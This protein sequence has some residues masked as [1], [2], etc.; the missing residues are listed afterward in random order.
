[1]ANWQKIDKKSLLQLERHYSQFEPYCHLNVVDMWGWR[2]GPNHW[3]KVGDTVVYRLNDYN[4]GSLYLTI[5][6]RSSA[7]EAIR[8][9]CDKNKSLKKITLKC[10]PEVTLKALGRWNAIIAVD[11]DPDNHDYIFEVETMVKFSSLELQHK[12]PLYRKLVRK[13]PYLKVRV[14]DHNQAPDRRLIYRVFKR[15]VLQTNSQ[16]WRKEFLA[17]KRILNLRREKM[18]C[19]GF[20]DG[21]KAIGYTINEPE[22]SGYYQAFSGKADRGYRDLGLFMEHETAKYILDNYGSRFINLQPDQGLE[23][24]RDYKTSLG[25]QRQLKKYILIIDTAKATANPAN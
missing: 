21:R 24:L 1:M 14:L 5:L 13:H 22:S 17:L 15:W 8:E 18:V 7:K 6:G 12:Y 9:L 2:A 3:F 20:F 23:G 25:P 19:L 10:V 11:E 16:D 4:D